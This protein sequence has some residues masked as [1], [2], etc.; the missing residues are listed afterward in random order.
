MNKIPTRRIGSNGPSVGAVG[1]GT[2]GAFLSLISLRRGI[3]IRHL[4][5][6]VHSMG[7]PTR[8]RHIRL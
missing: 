1:Y 2:M 6:S 3:Y 5:A 8:K 4:Q 7:P